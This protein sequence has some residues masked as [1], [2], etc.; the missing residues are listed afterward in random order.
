[1]TETEWLASKDPAAMLTWIQ[2]VCPAPKQG[3]PKQPPNFSVSDR[4]LRLFA[5][6]CCRQ[7]WH[8]LTDDVACSRCGGV[9]V[10]K[11][12]DTAIAFACDRDCP[13]CKGTGLINRSH[14]AVEVA[15]RFADGEATVEELDAARSGASTA[16][17]WEGEKPEHYPEWLA[18]VATA[19]EKASIITVTL[20]QTELAAIIPLAEQAALLREIVGNPFRPV[21]LPPGPLVRCNE[22]CRKPIKRRIDEL[23]SGGILG[24]GIGPM[25]AAQVIAEE[26]GFPQHPADLHK[27]WRRG[28]AWGDPCPT[29]KPGPCPWLTPTVLSLAHAAYEDRPPDGILDPERLAIL[30]DALEEAGCDGTAC[31]QCETVKGVGGTLAGCNHCGGTGIIPHPLLAHLRSPGPHVRGCWVL[32]LIRGVC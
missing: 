16:R 6:A 26:F 7:V 24:D 1:M 25:K 31:L 23:L 20:R 4:K 10:L 29:C 13:D 3:W 15:E 19:I 5:C 32:D 18:H 21:M 8:L 9:G 14:K 22:F 27:M 17:H 28:Q 11:G 2:R 12:R 30:A